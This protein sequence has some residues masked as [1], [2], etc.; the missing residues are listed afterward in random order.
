VH[1]LHTYVRETRALTLVS[2]ISL[3]TV[4]TAIY[5]FTVCLICVP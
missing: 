2:P 5:L 1:L 3:T 4:M